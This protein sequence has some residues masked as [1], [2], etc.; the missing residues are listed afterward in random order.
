MEKPQTHSDVSQQETHSTRHHTITQ[1]NLDELLTKISST[2]DID[3]CFSTDGKELITS[4]CLE[5]QLLRLVMIRRRVKLLD[6]PHLLHIDPAII[7]EKLPAILE[8]HPQIDL[9]EG[10]L[11]SDRYFDEL[12]EQIN[13][14]L[15]VTSHISI[16][17]L[18]AKYELSHELLLEAI[19]LRIPT[20]IHGQ[21]INRTELVSAD[22]PSILR[23]QLKGI[24]R[25]CTHLIALSELRNL[26]SI[27]GFSLSKIIG[28]MIAN[29]EVNGQL[30][31]GLYIS[32]KFISDRGN[33]IHSFFKQNDYVSY[34]FL[35]TNLHVSNP[36][37]FLKDLFSNEEAIFLQSC[38]YSAKKLATL[39]INI[40]ALLQSDGFVE[41]R[42]H[43]PSVFS[44]Y[45]IEILTIKHLDLKDYYLKK[46]VIF[47]VDYLDKCASI[48]REQFIEE[49]SSNPCKLISSDSQGGPGTGTKG[50]KGKLKASKSNAST[51]QESQVISK[52]RENKL[53]PSDS[54]AEL[55]SILFGLLKE[56]LN[57]L[58][59]KVDVEVR[60]SKKTV[61]VDLLD[62]LKSSVEEKISLLQLVLRSMNKVSSVPNLN[63]VYL[64]E[65][66]SGFTRPVV[67]DMI[68]YY[69][70]KCK[71]QLPQTWFKPGKL[72]NEA[73][74][75]Y[76]SQAKFA[77]MNTQSV[78]KSPDL[79]F[80]AAERL[81][82]ELQKPARDLLSQKK[83]EGFV[84]VLQDNIEAFDLKVTNMEKR[85]EK[86]MFSTQKKFIKEAILKENYTQKE[87]FFHLLEWF[88][89]DQTLFFGLDQ[90]EKSISLM[91]MSFFWSVA[92]ETSAEVKSLS[93]NIQEGLNAY[94]ASQQ[95][96][97]EEINN[98]L[99]LLI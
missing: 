13:G 51:L 87:K 30:V 78:F 12:C 76:N 47:A 91:S 1:S 14:E 84:K 29:Q 55:E 46:D 22:Y 28:D 69:C 34:E 99:L 35:T 60:E 37:P 31:N 6:V 26:Y 95:E 94:G 48:F 21:I 50:K 10:E 75:P 17:S 61:A 89:L 33:A 82:K 97:L 90:Q 79:L 25:A 93:Q 49:I 38:I 73:P 85:N 18:V 77:K 83:L 68:I 4:A 54:D 45:D 72:A 40:Q 39:K 64:N 41:L 52:L 66:A 5:H 67:E 3:Y 56:R 20:I 42:E 2:S 62:D 36:K 59:E 44:S 8:K 81:P 96:K 23:A 9:R 24:L 80:Q 16:S 65:K 88:L 58:K 71:I 32:E 7:D 53:F 98:K 57:V 92:K 74:E 15:Q 11:L 70:Q 63:M 27:T 43:L 86:T 19:E